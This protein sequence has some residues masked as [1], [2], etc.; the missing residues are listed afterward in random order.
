MIVER[1]P[2]I[3]MQLMGKNYSVPSGLTIMAAIEYAGYKLVR[4][5]G[6]RGGFCGACPTLYRRDSSH[7]VFTALACQTLV[8]DGMC[9][10]QMPFVPLLAKTYDLTAIEQRPNTLLRHFPEVAGCV[11]CGTCTRS[12]PQG[13]Q[14]MDYI[15][16]ALRGDVERAALL[17][18]DCISCGICSARCP[19]DI[20]H[21]AVGL[22]AR[23]IYGAYITPAAEHLAARVLELEAGRFTGE[24]DELASLPAAELRARYEARTFEAA[25]DAA[26]PFGATRRYNSQQDPVDYQDEFE[27]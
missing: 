16:A 27:G 4:G 10:V 22:L 3:T 5:A 18:F 24:L 20:K 12:C 1:A 6:C 17:S 25:P 11:A 26:E 2:L 21:Y 23:R 9:L 15:Q 8:E 14:V 19:A 7:R 13:L